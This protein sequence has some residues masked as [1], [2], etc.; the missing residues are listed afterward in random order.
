MTE[1]CQ[2]L[3]VHEAALANIGLAADQQGA[4]VGVNGRQ[5]THVLPH[6]LQ[7]SQAGSLL[8]HDGAHASLHES[9]FITY[10]CQKMQLVVSPRSTIKI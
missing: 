5:P 6:L 1:L 8:L 7:V 4:G 10:S 3:T 2:E 9:T